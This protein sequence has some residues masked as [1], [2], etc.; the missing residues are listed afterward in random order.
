M[1]QVPL[2]DES[3]QTVCHLFEPAV[4]GR[5]RPRRNPRHVL[6]AILWILLNNEKWHRLPA[7]FPPTQTC[8]AKWLE[9]SR[10]GTMTRVLTEL[11]PDR[12]VSNL[13]I[14]N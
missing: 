6:D 2:S 10:D 1:L 13:G 11:D 8:Y 12:V 9:W 14:S 4:T 3:W 7:I 5:G